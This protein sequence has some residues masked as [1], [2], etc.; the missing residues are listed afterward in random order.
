MNMDI[1]DKSGNSVG[2]SRLLFW[3]WRYPGG[4]GV[5]RW[6]KQC[7]CA[8]C[9]CCSGQTWVKGGKRADF[10]RRSASYSSAPTGF[11]VSLWSSV[12]WYKL[13]QEACNG[14]AL[15]NLKPSEPTP[16]LNIY[17]SWEELGRSL[18]ALNATAE[19]RRRFSPLTVSS[20]PGRGDVWSL[21]GALRAEG[22]LFI[23]TECF[24]VWQSGSMTLHPCK[25]KP[26]GAPFERLP[27]LWAHWQWLLLQNTICKDRV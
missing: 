3:F 7:R 6:T 22:M 26:D 21:Q 2:R 15:W 9:S 20:A 5:D 18:R 12:H 16:A 11:S 13:V 4:W 1:R 8:C 23:E 27:A 10:L 14:L 19:P 17:C 25:C 24:R